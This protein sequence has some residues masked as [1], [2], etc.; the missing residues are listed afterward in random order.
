MTE[1]QVGKWEAN[2][3]VSLNFI[4]PHNLVAYCSPRIFSWLLFSYLFSPQMEK[5]RCFISQRKSCFISQLIKVLFLKNKRQ[6]KIVI[7]NK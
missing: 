1:P 7:K 6:L 2:L 4:G 5:K 3:N